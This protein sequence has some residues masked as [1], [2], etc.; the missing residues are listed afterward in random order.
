MPRASSVQPI[1]RAGGKP[2]PAYAGDCMF[3]H[4]EI[5]NFKSVEHV[6]LSCRR[7]NV[8]IGEPNT[9]KSN[10]LEALGLISYVGHSSNPNSLRGFVRCED[11]SSLF[12]DGD[13][14]RELEIILN[15]AH[16][17]DSYQDFPYVS[18]PFRTRLQLGFS[19]GRFEGSVAIEG[20]LIQ[21]TAADQRYLPVGSGAY[22]ISGD[23]QSLSVR[24][25]PGTLG[26]PDTLESAAAFKFYR[27][28]P[29]S[30]FPAKGGRFLLPP[31]G[32]NLLALLL[33]NRDLR[34]DANRPFLSRGLRLGLRPQ[35]NKIEVLKEFDDVI[36]SH[37]YHLASDTFQR[38]VFYMAAL[39]TNSDSVLIFEEPEAHAFP[40]YTKYLAER[41]ALDERGNQFFISTHNPYFLLPILEK[42]LSDDIAV[43]I[44]YYDNN[45]T[46]IRQM[47]PDDL[48][49][50]SDDID[51]F[52]NIQMFLED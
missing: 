17:S 12:Y 23:Q 25:S 48:E 22:S 39:H 43:F 6:E 1:L 7:V 45:R 15:I 40:Y 14:N 34:V 16:T 31:S 13:I 30:T 50:I 4:L 27:F 19:N 10:I 24:R 32:A 21:E 20:A 51:V 52:S 11:T 29:R 49:I 18:E 28:A 37:P 35:E 9:G 2:K 38:L 26:I 36:V 47:S 42:T 33:Q 3:N 44:T 5:R 46:Q 41:I 8:L